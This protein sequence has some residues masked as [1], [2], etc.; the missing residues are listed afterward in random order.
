M[1]FSF[2]FFALWCATTAMARPGGSSLDQRMKQR[3]HNLQQMHSAGGSKPASNI[4]TAGSSGPSIQV[5]TN[6][7]AVLP[8]ENGSA[9]QYYTTNWAGAIITAPPTGETFN[10]VIATFVVPIPK[11]PVSGPGT[12]W[13]TAWVGIDGFTYGNA[14]LQTGVDWGVEVFA[15][16]SSAY[17]YWG[18]YEWYPAGWSDFTF[19]VAGNDT[20][21]LV[22]EA[23]SASVGLASMSNQRTGGSVSSM[24]K[25]P[26]N[27]SLLAGQNAEWIVEDFSSGGLVPFA[28]FGTVTFTGCTA[29]AGRTV[30]AVNGT[31]A[32]T[33]DIV[34]GTTKVPVTKSSFPATDQVRVSYI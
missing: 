9:T 7:T 3:T 25:A 30:V 12:W 14:I 32:S 16:G 1:K 4:R 33:I 10:I 17:G 31:T 24:L 26:S 2:P 6:E 8:N 23:P 28:D 34:N 5:P 29:E 15:D 11:P 18:W 13:G 22:I 21:E 27:S 19:E 20:I